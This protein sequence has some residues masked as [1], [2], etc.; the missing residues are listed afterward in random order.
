M[1]FGLG[2]ADRLR[3][4]LALFD[5]FQVGHRH[6]SEANHLGALGDFGPSTG[7]PSTQFGT[8]PK[9]VASI[10]SGVA[11]E[12]RSVNVELLTG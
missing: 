7:A 8:R 3:L 4:R 12:A 1:N 6:Q 11:T 5:V 2:A 10:V 9:A